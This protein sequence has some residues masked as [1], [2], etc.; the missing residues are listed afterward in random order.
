MIEPETE[1]P[2]MNDLGTMNGWKHI[3]PGGYPPEYNA[4]V[5]KGHRHWQQRDLLLSHWSEWGCD[6]CR[7]KYSVDS[8]G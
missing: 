5:A 1:T 7:F 8:S 3:H 6:I 2:P 4:C